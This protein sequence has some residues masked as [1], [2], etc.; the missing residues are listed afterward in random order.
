[1]FISLSTQSENFWTQP[2]I[3]IELFVWWATF[4]TKSIWVQLEFTQCTKQFLYYAN[5]NQNKIS[6]WVLLGSDAM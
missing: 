1:L 5:T 4:F 3:M 6:S 2:H